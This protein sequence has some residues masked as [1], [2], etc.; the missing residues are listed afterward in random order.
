MATHSIQDRAQAAKRF[1]DDEVMGAV[2]DELRADTVTQW[3]LKATVEERE[4][5]AQQYRAIEAIRKALRILVE[6]G[7]FRSEVAKP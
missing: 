3:A 6:R 5:C 2:F 1:L 4:I 7:E